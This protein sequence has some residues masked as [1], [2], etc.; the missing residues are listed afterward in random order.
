MCTGWNGLPT[1]NIS[2]LSSTEW[3]LCLVFHDHLLAT[4]VASPEHLL[5]SAYSDLCWA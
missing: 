3:Y 4:M 5:K 2:A 1:T